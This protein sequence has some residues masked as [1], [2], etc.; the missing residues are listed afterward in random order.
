[1]E[2]QIKQLITKGLKAMDEKNYERALQYY[3]QALEAAQKL[4]DSG[5][6]ADI[7]LMV[8]KIIENIEGAIAIK[9]GKVKPSI[10]VDTCPLCG[11]TGEGPVGACPY[12]HGSGQTATTPSSTSAFLS[13]KLMAYLEE[14]S[15]GKIEEVGGIQKEYYKEEKKKESK[16]DLE[17]FLEEA[18]AAIPPQEAEAP[19]VVSGIVADESFT[20]E[21]LSAPAK[22]IALPTSGTAAPK[23]PAGSAGAGAPK[24]QPAPPPP[25]AMAR[26]PD[27]TPKSVPRPKPAP[28]AKPTARPPPAPAPAPSQPLRKP[29]MAKKEARREA[30]EDEGRMVGDITPASPEPTPEP[31]KRAAAPK[32]IK[33]FGDVSSPMEMTEKKEYIVAVCLRV[34]KEDVVGMP[35]PMEIVVPVVGPPIIEVFLMGQDFKVDQARRSLIVPLDRDSDIL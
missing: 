13:S 18:E 5:K 20:K 21:K 6:R 11:G 16:E 17:K 30:E 33:R 2:E 32:K 22:Q 23:Y 3:R 34:L 8:K 19:S 26:P 9:S 4:E 12:C 31:R 25:P 14:T 27:S 7:I 1:M 10:G 28:A 24:P 29:A 35:V 15:I